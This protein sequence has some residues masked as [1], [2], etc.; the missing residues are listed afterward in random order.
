[1][2]NGLFFH[3]HIFIIQFL[4]KIAFLKPLGHSLGVYQMWTKRSD[5]APKSGCAIFFLIF[6][7]KRVLW[8]FFSFFF[9]MFDPLLFFSPSFILT[10]IIF[11]KNDKI[12][13]HYNGIS[14]PWFPD[15][16]NVRASFASLIT[17][18]FEP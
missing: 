4:S 8:G 13:N 6:V 18:P 16:C 1:M 10:T 2:S 14:L 7:Q 3:G 17:K 9:L 11:S 12:K 5:H 15:I